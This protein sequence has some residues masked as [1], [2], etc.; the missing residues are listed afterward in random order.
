MAKSII[1]NYSIKCALPVCIHKTGYH[2]AY[3][4][5]DGTPAARWKMFCNYHRTGTGKAA[6]ENWKM[7]KGCENSDGRYG[8]VCTSSITNAAQIDIN[9]KD[10]NRQNQ[11]PK[12]LERLCKVC[13]TKVT[14][15]EKH[16]LNRY[17][18]TN[19]NFD[20]FFSELIEE[21]KITT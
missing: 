13:H 21:G 4:K 15:D 14:Q 1:N 2:K 7:E 17:T 9:H 19:T 6:V 16:Y 20:N 10:G 18:N 5:K 12:N 11:D 8:Y 3:T